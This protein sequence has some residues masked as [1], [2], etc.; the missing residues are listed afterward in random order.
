[1][2]YRH[3]ARNLQR[4][5]QLR[6]GDR[7]TRLAGHNRVSPAAASVQVSTSPYVDRL[8]VFANPGATARSWYPALRSRTLRRD[9]FDPS[10][11]GEQTA[12]R[13]CRHSRCMSGAR[14]RRALSASC[15]DPLAGH[16]QRNGCALRVSCVLRGRR[17]LRARRRR[18]AQP[19]A[20]AP[21]LCEERGLVWIFNGPSPA[22]PCRH[23]RPDRRVVVD[24]SAAARALHLV[25]AANGLDITWTRGLHD[26]AFTQPPD[27]AHEVSVTMCARPRLAVL[28]L[29]RW[30]APRGR[31]RA[32]LYD[33]GGS[34][35]W[36]TCGRRARFHVLFSG[37]PAR[38]RAAA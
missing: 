19:A 28:A 10:D 30:R 23:R 8:R 11:C 14:N 24:V 32:F 37:R 7:R 4:F 9:R 26:M 15:G 34:L 21:T 31:G 20:F 22:F 27:G 18:H 2:G 38:V 25:S 36:T 29:R 12:R 1:M 6:L 13:A 35:A 16:G 17:S 5:L 33:F 3:Y